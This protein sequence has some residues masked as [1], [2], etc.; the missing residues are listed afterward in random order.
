MAPAQ[1]AAAEPEETA[2]ALDTAPAVAEE[3]T[4]HLQAEAPP[5]EGALP[6]A[7]QPLDAWDPRTFGGRE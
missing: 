5:V 2:R 4:A 1:T 7:A 6:A 3:P